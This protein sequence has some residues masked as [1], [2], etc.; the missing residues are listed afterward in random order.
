MAQDTLA[1]ILDEIKSLELD[2]IQVLER[3]LGEQRQ[4]INYGYSLEEWR[5]LTSLVEAGLMTEIAPKR[6]QAHQEFVPVPIKGKPLSETVA[7]ERR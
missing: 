4:A 6:T 5:V 7:E 3:T 1:H 2:E